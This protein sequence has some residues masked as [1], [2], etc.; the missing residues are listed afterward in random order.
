LFNVTPDE[1]RVRTA[2]TATHVWPNKEHHDGTVNIKPFPA[3]RPVSFRWPK[4]VPPPARTGFD[5]LPL[6]P[7]LSINGRGFGIQ[8]YLRALLGKP[9]R[10]RRQCAG[11]SSHVTSTPPGGP[12]LK[13]QRD[14][15]STVR[16]RE[17]P[18]KPNS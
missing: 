14:K 12:Q 7:Y 4:E 15:D 9:S 5:T 17:M 2:I 3:T 6:G 11:L 13:A 10:V 8:R 18:A 16:M 1:V